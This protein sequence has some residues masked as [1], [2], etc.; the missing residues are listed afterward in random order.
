MENP[1]ESKNLFTLLREVKR[2]SGAWPLLLIKT[3]QETPYRYPALL[4]QCAQVLG[5]DQITLAV[6]K[7]DS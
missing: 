1:I 2:N 6:E 7:E 4:F 5:V 3:D